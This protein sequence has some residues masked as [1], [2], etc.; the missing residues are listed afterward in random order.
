VVL[1]QVNRSRVPSRVVADKR[2][3][4]RRDTIMSKVRKDSTITLDDTQ[5]VISAQWVSLAQEIGNGTREKKDVRDTIDFIRESGKFTTRAGMQMGRDVP[6]PDTSDVDDE[7]IAEIVAMCRSKEYGAKRIA[8]AIRIAFA[9]ASSSVNETAKVGQPEKQEMYLSEAGKR[10]AS[11]DM[12]MLQA[13]GT[14]DAT[15]TKN[16]IAKWFN[17]N[18]AGD[19]VRKYPYR[20]RPLIPEDLARDT[21]DPIV[22]WRIHAG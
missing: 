13:I 22:D 12:S 21:E 10:A 2:S 11:G 8:T 4:D 9:N 15:A 20:T 16:T 18:V 6:A 7:I 1:W 5:D 14:G 19:K 3:N 17:D